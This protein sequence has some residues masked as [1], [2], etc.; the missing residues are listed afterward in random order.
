MTHAR[1]EAGFT[2]IE[3][4]VAITL[5]SILSV[6]F[7]QV[8]L[9]GVRGTDTTQD[10]V[11]ISS[12]ARLG[13]NRMVRETREADVISCAGGGGPCATPTSYTVNIDFNGDGV[14]DPSSMDV[15]TFTY[16]SDD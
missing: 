6:G 16:D 3:V 14:Y 9:S 2:M 10:V 1:E 15:I 11:T 12:E 8:M 7:Y 4:L 13:L 5:F